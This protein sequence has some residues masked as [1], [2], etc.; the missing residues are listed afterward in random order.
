MR[1]GSCLITK[2]PNLDEQQCDFLNNICSLVPSGFVRVLY[3]ITIASLCCMA[4]VHL[5]MYWDSLNSV[6]DMTNILPHYQETHKT[7]KTREQ[8]IQDVLTQPIQIHLVLYLRSIRFIRF[9][10]HTVQLS[11]SN[12][13]IWSKMNMTL[14]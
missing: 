9:I 1:M 12:R 8:W 3:Y 7:T 11:S 13:F 2:E 4:L 5:T 14:S 6:H 10:H